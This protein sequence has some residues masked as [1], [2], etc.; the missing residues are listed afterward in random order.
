MTE[1]KSLVLVVDDDPQLLKTAALLLNERYTVSLADSGEA[2]LDRLRRGLQPDLILLDVDMPGMSGY[3]V[4]SALEKLTGAAHIPV[5]F[6]TGLTEEADE[7]RGLRSG[8]V[9]YIRKPFSREVLLA[10]MAMHI[11][12]GKQLREL[13]RAGMGE[14]REQ[15]LRETLTETEWKVAQLLAEGYNG[16]EISDKLHY[17]YSH[18]KKRLASI[19]KKLELESSSEL[20]RFLAGQ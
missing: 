11:E 10:R 8:A 15:L 19:R 7:L 9:D 3:E 20:K 16:K 2:A 12:R 6:L 14:K 4:M 17:S 1:E 18:V 13:G 5:V